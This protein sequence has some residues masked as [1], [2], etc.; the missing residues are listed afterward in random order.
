LREFPREFDHSEME[1]FNP[2]HC[3]SPFLECA[4]LEI[5][6]PLIIRNGLFEF[7]PGLVP[8]NK[9]HALLGQ[10]PIPLL[11]ELFLVGQGLIL[12]RLG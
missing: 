9:R 12:S 1:L 4:D 2:L 3:L 6:S 11:G 10:C 5:D 8:R 7:R